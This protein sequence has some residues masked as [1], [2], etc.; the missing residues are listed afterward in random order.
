MREPGQLR[1]VLADEPATR[2]AGAALAAAL[3]AADPP[4]IFVTVAGELGAGKTT[5]VRG[6]LEALGTAGPVRS[7]TYTLIESYPAGG[8]RVHHLDWYRLA[9]PEELEGVGFR[10]LLAP[11]HWVLVEWPERAPSVAALADLA[12]ELCYEG[13]GRRLDVRGATARGAG[14]VRLWRQGNA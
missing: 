1:L 6:L 2:R 10:E 14:V 9:G 11:G 3:T 4:A 12:L 13:R 5:L 7:P 8:R